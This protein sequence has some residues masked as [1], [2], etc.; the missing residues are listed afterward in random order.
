MCEMERKEKRKRAKVGWVSY[1]KN[2]C[3]IVSVKRERE[4]RKT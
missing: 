4:D 3:V 2:A 1:K